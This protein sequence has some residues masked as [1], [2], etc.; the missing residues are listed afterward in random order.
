V[1]LAL[2]AQR[3]RAWQLDLVDLPHPPGPG[4]EHDDPI[5]EIDRLLDVAGNE[6]GGLSGLGQTRNSSSCMNSRV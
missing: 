5:G 4:A 3:T 2:D 6:D 1:R